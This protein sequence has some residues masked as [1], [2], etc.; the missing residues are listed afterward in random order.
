M[1]VTVEFS[2]GTKTF[3]KD[4]KLVA[5]GDVGALLRDQVAAVEAMYASVPGM[6]LS[7]QGVPQTVTNFQCRA[8]L[9]AANLFD[10]VDAALKAQGGVALQAWEY[11]ATVHRQ[12]PLVLSLAVSLGLT[13]QQIDAMFVQA[14]QIAV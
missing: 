5:G 4:Y 6:S 7:V 11:S 9:I 3:R 14:S 1:W 12:S 8:M 10:Q 2:D 13:D